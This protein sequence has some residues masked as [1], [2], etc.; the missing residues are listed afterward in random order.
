MEC[1][2][3]VKGHEY[4]GVGTQ[5]IILNNSYHGVCWCGTPS[6]FTVAKSQVSW[7]MLLICKAVFAK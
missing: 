2:G 3:I 7:G 4:Q 1:S 5:G 6:H